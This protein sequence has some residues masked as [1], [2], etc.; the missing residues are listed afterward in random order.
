MKTTTKRGI[1]A[2]VAALENIERPEGF[3]DLVS[4]KLIDD[5]GGNGGWLAVLKVEHGGRRFEDSYRVHGATGEC[6][7]LNLVELDA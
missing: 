5:R 6:E 3:A 4:V 2:A 1:A 7:W